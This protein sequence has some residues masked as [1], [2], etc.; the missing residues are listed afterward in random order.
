MK[1]PSKINQKSIKNPSKIDLGGVLGRLKASW[2]VLAASRGDKGASRR[3]P[4]ASWG[5]NMVRTWLPKR[6]QNRL[7]IE[8]KNDQNFDAS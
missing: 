7:K 4:G 8:S 1:N 5:A 3:R 6:S 2:G